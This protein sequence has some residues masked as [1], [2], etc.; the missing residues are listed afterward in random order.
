[1]PAGGSAEPVGASL[2]SAATFRSPWALARPCSHPRTSRASGPA[3][4]KERRR[5]GGSSR[6]RSHAGLAPAGSFT[7]AV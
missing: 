7:K 2:G 6:R 1:M 5:V 4:G 3:F